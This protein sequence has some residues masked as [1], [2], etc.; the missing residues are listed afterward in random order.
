MNID[1]EQAKQ[2]IE[3]I[4]AE[5]S[6]H[7]KIVFW[8]DSPK[9]FLDSVASDT[10]KDVKVIIYENNPFTIKT[11]LNIE[12]P[13]SNYLVYFPFDKPKDVDNWLADMTF[14]VTEYYA[15]TVALTMRK[16][17]V[18]S[19][20]LRGVIEKHIHFFDSQSRIDS[21]AK[22]VT[23]SDSTDPEELE[24]GMM[25]AIVKNSDYNKIDFI[26]RELIFDDVEEGDKYSQM[27]KFGFKEPFWELVSTQF[28]Y[29]GKQEIS[30]LRKSFLLT[31]I[32][33]K[34]SFKMETPILKSLIIKN[35]TENIQIFV[36]Q[37]LMSDKRYPSLDK[38]VWDEMRIGEL[39]S[40]K[41]IDSIGSCDTFSEFDQSIITAITDALANGS[42]DYDF[43]FNLIN[44]K[45]LASKWFD[46]FKYEYH[47][48]LSLISFMREINVTIDPGLDSEQYIHD[49]AEKWW[50]I[51]NSYRHAINDFNG[52]E[53][54]SDSEEKL[55]EIIDGQYEDRFL[56]KL[57]PE[58]SKSLKVKEPNYS[59]GSVD[60]STQF[61]HKRLN[62]QA[63]KQFVIISDALRYEVAQDLV[64][65]INQKDT[66]K[67]RAVLSYQATTLPSIT[68]FGMASLLPNKELSYQ[69]KQV[70]VN[71][72]PTNSTSARDAILK[73]YDSGY[74]AIQYDDIM[75]MNKAD[76]REYMRDKSVVYIYHDTIDNAGEHD[77]NNVFAA[78]DKAIEQIVSLIKKLYNVLQISNYIVTSD[79]GF[80]YR[81]KKID[82]S[83]KYKSISF[84]GIDDYSQRYAIVNDDTELS[85]TNRFSMGYLGSCDSKV[86]VPYGYDL[87]KKAGGGIQYIHGGASLQEIIT[88]I[89]T[90]SEMRSSASANVVE[91]VKVR[92]KSVIRKIMNKSFALQFEQCEKVEDKKKEANVKVYFIDEDRNVISDEKIFIANKTTDNLNDRTIEMRFLLKNQGYDRDKRY[93]LVM[94]DAE[95][96]NELCQEI[97]FVIDIVKFKMF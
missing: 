4:F 77:E 9:N 95:I 62:T 83:S 67:G 21:L 58:F 85:F 10:Y 41:G 91:P 94:E 23:I 76:L 35:D 61:F 53:D 84:M 69:S 45:R 81:N 46:D 6:G 42:Y 88:P 22:H 13:D 96:G 29:S 47:F 31:S 82:E 28:S 65:A 92:L 68:M 26:L 79:H 37:V 8:Y 51:D 64:K 55:T 30:E 70:L 11:V 12:D 5:P 73:S 19:G 33:K 40:T 1:Y 38:A 56:N 90:L 43:Y 75:G 63:K 80:I 27:E 15:D 59:F 72:K 60:S 3:K 49:Y 39:I 78:C 52:I 87:F 14:Y 17:N 2:Q 50:K 20:T 32:A 36:D 54:P 34:V 7:R 97:P 86:I 93:Y 18:T 24:L 48:I 89:V 25:S 71:G 66:F 57:G 44:D 74:A 16:L